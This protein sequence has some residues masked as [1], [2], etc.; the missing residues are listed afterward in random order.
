VTATSTSISRCRSAMATTTP[1]QP[2]ATAWPGDV[3]QRARLPAARHHEARFSD[4]TKRM[5]SRI[6]YALLFAPGTCSL[7]DASHLA[8]EPCRTDRALLFIQVVAGRQMLRAAGCQRLMKSAALCRADSFA[9]LC[10]LRGCVLH[11]ERNAGPREWVLIEKR[12]I[13]L[14]RGQKA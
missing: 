3:L 6:R 5:E 13:R 10:A 11:V 9:A 12:S 2:H 14:L 7:L 4:T 1:A 8:V